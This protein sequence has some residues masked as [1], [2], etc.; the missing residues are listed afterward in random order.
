MTTGLVN[1][2]APNIGSKRIP[3]GWLLTGLAG[4][5]AGTYR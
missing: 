2:S 4:T 5:G 3:F 1:S